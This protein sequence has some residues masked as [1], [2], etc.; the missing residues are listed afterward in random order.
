[1]LSTGAEMTMCSLF[2]VFTTPHAH[3]QQGIHPQPRLYQRQR[4]QGR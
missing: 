4:E 2:A 1:M 3:I